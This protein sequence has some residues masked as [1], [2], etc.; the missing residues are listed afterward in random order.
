MCAPFGK[1][2]HDLNKRGD[3]KDVESNNAFVKTAILPFECVHNVRNLGKIP[4]DQIVHVF[5]EY[6]HILEP[7]F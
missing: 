2:V 3:I 4:I 7:D 1:T 6:V 5:R